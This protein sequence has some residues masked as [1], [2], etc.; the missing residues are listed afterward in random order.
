V[1]PPN[2]FHQTKEGWSNRR[3]MIVCTIEFEANGRVRD[4]RTCYFNRYSKDIGYWI[5]DNGYW[6]LD[7]GY[8]PIK[9]TVAR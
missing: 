4:R 5:L 8:W 2:S 7:I 9:I 3:L 1:E 6:I